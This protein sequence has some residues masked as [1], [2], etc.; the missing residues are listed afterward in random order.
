MRR[1]HILVEGQTEEIV[2]REVIAPYFT[3][4]DSGIT[5]SIHT[6]K[7]PAG[8]PAFKGGLSRWPRLHREL[9]MLLRDS[10]IT[11][12]TTLLDYYAFPDDAPGMADRP[13]GSPYDR[14]GHVERALT[15][16]V[17]GRRFLPHL[18]LHETEA[19]VLAGCDLLGELM[20][21]PVGAAAL[22]GVV[23]HANG[24]ELV[25]DGPSTAPSK[26]ILDRYPRY[27]K[28]IDGPLVI[29]DLGPDRIRQ[30]CPHADQWFTAIETALQR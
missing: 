22:A 16:A 17:G 2:V 20:A 12:L 25:D 18:V 30:S 9:E 6:T 23:R 19:W 14:I 21:D 7:R 3:G 15:G 10:S 26:R 13:H 8:G 28:T 27:R 11:L 29:A 5:W 24:L 1:L 4:P